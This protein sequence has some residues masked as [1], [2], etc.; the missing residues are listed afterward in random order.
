MFLT[1]RGS[2]VRPDR[3]LACRFYPLG[4]RIDVGGAGVALA[5]RAG[6]GPARGEE[7]QPASRRWATQWAEATG[8]PSSV[9]TVM[10]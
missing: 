2:G 6:G 7:S 10:S 1:E 8:E 5:R 9:A 4:R 3:P